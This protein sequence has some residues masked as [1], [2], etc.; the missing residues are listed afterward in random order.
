[1]DNSKGCLAV[2]AKTRRG[3]AC[4]RFIQDVWLSTLRQCV[5]EKCLVVHTSMQ[6]MQV[7]VQCN[8]NGCDCDMYTDN[9][10]EGLAVHAMAE[11]G[12]ATIDIYSGCL[13]VHIMPICT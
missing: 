7:Y 8:V 6:T 5:H 11:R 4:N 9:L 2:H 3:V 10:K 12:K 1:M 13:S